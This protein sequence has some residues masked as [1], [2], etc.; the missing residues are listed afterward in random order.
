MFSA[1]VRLGSAASSRSREALATL[2]KTLA[3]GQVK[4]DEIDDVNGAIARLRQAMEGRNQKVLDAMDK[5]VGIED[6][7]TRMIEAIT[8]RIEQIESKNASLWQRR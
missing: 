7:H 4:A 8:G 5:I 2:Q 6:K 1:S 3:D